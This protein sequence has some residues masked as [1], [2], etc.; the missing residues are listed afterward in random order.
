M[1]L[2]QPMFFITRNLLMMLQIENNNNNNNIFVII[3]SQEYLGLGGEKVK[4]EVQVSRK[5]N[6]GRMK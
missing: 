2:V 6:M 1:L 3:M 5:K 4:N